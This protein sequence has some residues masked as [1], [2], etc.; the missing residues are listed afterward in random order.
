MSIA[1]NNVK[2]ALYLVYEPDNDAGW[3]RYI[4]NDIEVTSSISESKKKRIWLRRTFNLFEKDHMCLFFK[5]KY[6]NRKTYFNICN[7]RSNV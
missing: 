3:I 5:L 4:L 7:Y 2:L 1:F 6:L